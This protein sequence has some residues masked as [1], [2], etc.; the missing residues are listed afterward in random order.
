M[1]SI[2]KI[3]RVWPSQT[4]PSK[5][6]PNVP[7]SSR[8]AVLQGIGNGEYA[9][10]FAVTLFGDDATLPLDTGMMIAAKLRFR[11]RE[12]NGKSYQDVMVE[13]LGVIGGAVV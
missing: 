13:G 5:A 11:T 9:D 12:Y 6:N 10:T 1:E 3:V 4:F 2:F 7:V 8:R